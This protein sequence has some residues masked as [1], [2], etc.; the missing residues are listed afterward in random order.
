MPQWLPTT[1]ETFFPCT[2]INPDLAYCVPEEG[3]NWFVDAMCILKDAKNV[4]EAH[5]WINFMASTEAN[6]QNMD[7][8]WYASPNTEALE[9]YPEWY[10]EAVRRASGHGAV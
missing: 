1:P 4:G 7:F 3:S 10:E 2:R 6:L 5:E 9:M 8:I